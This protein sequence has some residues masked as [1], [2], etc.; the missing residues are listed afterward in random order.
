[1]KKKKQLTNKE[2]KTEALSWLKGMGLNVSIDDTRSD[3]EIIVE[4]YI[5]CIKYFL[6]GKL[7]PIT[8]FKEG[9]YEWLMTESEGDIELDSIP[10]DESEL[11]ECRYEIEA[12]IGDNGYDE[13]TVIK[14]LNDKIV[15]LT[16]T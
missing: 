9:V 10:H 14:A 13:D 4:D 11:S 8:G 12:L 7:V 15:V 16:Q 1:M 5:K 2:M 3:I 6:N